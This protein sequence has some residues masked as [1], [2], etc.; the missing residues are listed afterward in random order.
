MMLV[1]AAHP[2]AAVLLR[3]RR[4]ASEERAY[5]PEEE[6]EPPQDLRRN[7]AVGSWMPRR[8]RGFRPGTG[9]G[10][11]WLPRVGFEPT[12]RKAPPPQD[13]VS[14]SSTTWANRA[15]YYC[16]D[17]APSTRNG[18][19][20]GSAHRASLGAGWADDGAAGSAAGA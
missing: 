2:A 13:G 11:V 17:S 18:P 6:R 14:T 15:A 9:D 5:P 8:G 3:H 10:I 19:R 16:G 20:K 1:A 4:L 7:A 12:R